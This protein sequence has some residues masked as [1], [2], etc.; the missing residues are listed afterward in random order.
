MYIYKQQAIY[1]IMN[2]H[3]S[4]Y[5][6]S[7]VHLGLVVRSATIQQYDVLTSQSIFSFEHCF[8]KLCV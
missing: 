7:N 1:K 4:K 6:Y 5:Q 3:P 8:E 2:I